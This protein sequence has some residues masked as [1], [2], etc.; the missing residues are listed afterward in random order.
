VRYLAFDLLHLDGHDVTS[1]PYE[2]RRQLLRE[3]LDDDEHWQVPEHH[4]GEG[5]ELL[6]AVVAQGL[7]G[8]IAKRLGSSYQPGS[9]RGD[10]RKVKRQQRQEFVIGGWTEGAGKRSDSLG[11]LLLGYYDDAGKLHYAGNV[12]TGFDRAMLDRL[13][14]KLARRAR[15]SSPFDVN[16][17]G[18]TS[19]PGKWQTIRSNGGALARTIHY[20]TPSL[21][22]EVEFTEFT[23]DGTL[24]HPSFKG[25]RDDKDPR[26]VVREDRA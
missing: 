25:L 1:L 12:G 15:K 6:D 24:R 2:Q 3:L 4:V 7:E 16:S 21:V 9:R 23:R 14:R 8:V 5:T 13:Q 26:T 17:P 18:A 11:A 20:V 19:T 10:W 22:C